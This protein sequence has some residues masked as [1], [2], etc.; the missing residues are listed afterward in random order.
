MR[1]RK[2]VRLTQ[3]FNTAVLEASLYKEAG[4]FVQS[5]SYLF[6]ALDNA[7]QPLS[8]VSIDEFNNAVDFFFTSLLDTDLYIKRIPKTS[9]LCAP[10]MKA[11]KFD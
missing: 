6:E 8:E 5:C 11:F 10:E 2:N 7:D 4:S 3:D 9:S 1:V